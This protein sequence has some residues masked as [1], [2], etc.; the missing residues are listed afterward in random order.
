[1]TDATENPSHE[2]SSGAASLEGYLYQLDVSV[3]QPFANRT[4]PVGL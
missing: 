3:R 1:M 2:A 4:R